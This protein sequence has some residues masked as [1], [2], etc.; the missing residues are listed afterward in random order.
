[1]IGPGA[2]ATLPPKYP[3]ALTPLIHNKRGGICHP[4][5][6]IHHALLRWLHTQG[7]RSPAMPTSDEKWPDGW[8]ITR[9]E[10]FPGARRA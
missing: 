7:E 1:M 9:K 4:P 10:L 6:V 5:G 3:M 2:R 8:L